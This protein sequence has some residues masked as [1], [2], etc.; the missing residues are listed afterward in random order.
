LNHLAAEAA[1]VV[2]ATVAEGLTIMDGETAIG[3]S[4]LSL[5]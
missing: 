4:T 2:E 3:I 1:V 5:A